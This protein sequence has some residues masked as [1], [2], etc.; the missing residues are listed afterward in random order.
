MEG[1]GGIRGHYRPP[2]PT[3]TPAD[4]ECADEAALRQLLF[5]S[6]GEL[7]GSFVLGP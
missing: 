4:M 3:P 2:N 6:G 5:L 1:G 7:M